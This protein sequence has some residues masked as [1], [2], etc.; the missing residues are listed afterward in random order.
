MNKLTRYEPF[1]ELLSMQKDMNNLFDAFFNRPLYDSP[2]FRSPM[3]DL[4]PTD[5]DIV[6]KA[7]LPGIE[8]DDINIEVTGDTLTIQGEIWDWRSSQPLAYA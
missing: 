8:A 1:D 5:D 4:Y 3:I 2:E 6:V 7:S